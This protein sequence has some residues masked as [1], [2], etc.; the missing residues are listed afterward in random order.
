MTY[1]SSDLPISAANRTHAV[2]TDVRFMQDSERGA[3]LPITADITYVPRC[4]ID[5]SFVTRSSLYPIRT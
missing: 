4:P 3:R 5:S 1:D 2:R